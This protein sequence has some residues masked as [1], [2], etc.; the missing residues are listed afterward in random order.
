LSNIWTVPYSFAANAIRSGSKQIQ[1]LQ[2]ITKTCIVEFP[3]ALEHKRSF[4]RLPE[5]KS[6]EEIE[7]ALKLPLIINAEPRY[8]W[9]NKYA[10][11]YLR[12]HE[13]K[14][15]AVIAGKG[16]K[17]L[18]ISIPPNY[19]QAYASRPEGFSG[20]LYYV[21]VE[22]VK[23]LV[24]P[25]SM[26]FDP[27]NKRYLYIYFRRMTPEDQQKWLEERKEDPNKVQIKKKKKV[28]RPPP[29]KAQPAKK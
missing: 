16:H 15:P 7:E 29:P 28:L 8:V 22:G 2:L 4:A 3:F 13:N 5:W 10:L 26:Q 11:G 25:T 27:R 23:H 21:T 12:K 14:I 18:L 24:K 6:L 19:I 20:R 1:S 9:G 17:D